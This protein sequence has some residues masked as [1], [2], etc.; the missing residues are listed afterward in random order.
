M[1]PDMIFRRP[2][3]IEQAAYAEGPDAA[4]GLDLYLL[5][6]LDPFPF[7]KLAGEQDGIGTGKEQERVRDI[8]AFIGELVIPDIAVL[9]HVHA[10]DHERSF[11]C[12]DEDTLR[13]DHRYGILNAGDL[14]NAF[15]EFLGKA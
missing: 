11:L 8:G 14:L 9:E 3:G 5:I 13:I 2:F 6:E 7:R 4:H 15:D 10:E 12:T 1:L